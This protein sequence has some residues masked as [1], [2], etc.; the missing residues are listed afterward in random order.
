V[1]GTLPFAFEQAHVFNTAL[2]Y[3]FGNNW[4]LGTVVHFNTG[5]PESGQVTSQTQRGVS[6]EEGGSEWVRQ[7]QDRVG[8]LDSFFRVDFRAAKSWA[9]EDFTLDAYLD[10]LNIS[11]QQEVF[12]Y[13]YGNNE[14]TL[15]RKPTGLPIILPL[16][17]LKGT[18]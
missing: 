7:D 3:K 10:V 9:M 1:E 8:R 11:A 18:Y 5:R 6:R 15:E 16:L 13:E 14:G 2:S 17:G 12:A 4:T